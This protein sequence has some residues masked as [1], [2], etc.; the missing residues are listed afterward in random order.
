MRRVIGMDL[1]R[2]FAEVVFWE[3]G[4]AS[5]STPCIAVPRAGYAPR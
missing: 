2:T 4:R 3:D 5:N 1:H